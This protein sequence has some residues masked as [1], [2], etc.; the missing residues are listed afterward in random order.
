V[1]VTEIPSYTP[2]TGTAISRDGRFAAV[3]T[4]VLDAAAGRRVERTWVLDLDG[5]AAAWAAVGPPTASVHGVTFLADGRL[6]VIH[7]LDGVRT[8]GLVDPERPGVVEAAVGARAGAHS[9]KAWAGG[10][11]C[12]GMD[13]EGTR[14][15]WGWRDTSAPPEALTPARQ[16]VADWAAIGVS[17]A[18]AW[19]IVPQRQV[20]APVPMNLLYRSGDP[21]VALEVPDN[22]LAYL[23]VS[24]AGQIAVL[25]RPRDEPLTQ[26]R[27][28]VVGDAGASRWLADEPGWITGYDWDGETL[29]VALDDGVDGKIVSAA[30]PGPAAPWGDGGRCS[31]GRTGTS[32]S[33][34]GCEKDRKAVGS[35][36]FTLP[37][38]RATSARRG[39]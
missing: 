1:K 5:R 3:V 28:W 13:S 18:L 20:G 19:I 32:R 21:P 6:A 12:L 8:V 22:P 11:G 29:V 2:I 26:P 14:R 24:D 25:A 23:A 35:H 34:C 38:R 27:L 36:G 33:T 10:L 4:P 15:V 7:E 17:G 16:S 39:G 9:L 30:G 31:C 37:W